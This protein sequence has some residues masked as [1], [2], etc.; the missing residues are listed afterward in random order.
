MARFAKELGVSIYFCPIETGLKDGGKNDNSK[1]EFALSPEQL[2]D[3]C[4][5]IL[6]LKR[7]GFPINNSETYLRTF[8]GGK[9][10][11]VC[12]APVFGLCV[13]A[14]GSIHDCASPHKPLANARDV[15]LAE[16][17]LR[18]DVQGLR[19]PRRCSECN[20]PNIID[21][22]YIWQLRGE[23]LRNFLGQYLRP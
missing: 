4:E 17:L 2:S 15:S 10:P 5:R 22:S 21:A 23:S 18:R 12:C 3:T 6:S 7:A 16:L 1:E 14:D 11:Y 9:K 20:N 19:R 13:K 8:I